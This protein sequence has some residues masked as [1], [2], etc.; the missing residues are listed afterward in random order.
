MSRMV[1]E[2]AASGLRERHWFARVM[3]R[4]LTSAGDAPRAEQLALR[5][6]VI[7]HL[8]SV[9]VGVLRQAA[10][11][12]GRGEAINGL[13]SLPAMLDA[14]ADTPCPEAGL[15]AEALSANQDPLAWL[16]GEMMAACA[17][18]GLS[19][20]PQ[21]PAEDN[22]LALRVEDP[23]Q[24]LA[25]GD[26]GRLQAAVDRVHTLLEDVGGHNQEW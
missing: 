1:R 10:A 9:L 18:S 7:F 2:E 26:L 13:L 16:H 6:A 5:G 21:P 25:E 14:L 20:R 24:L 22:A 3:L 17:A 19:R 23:Y 4:Q 12:I 8:Y 15:I 11:G